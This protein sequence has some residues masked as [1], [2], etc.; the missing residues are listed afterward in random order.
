RVV[1]EDSES[2]RLGLHR[3]RAFGEI[4]PYLRQDPDI[5]ALNRECI[6][7]NR[8]CLHYLTDNSAAAQAALPDN[9]D[10][11][12]SYRALLEVTPLARLV[13]E[14]EISVQQDL[15]QATRLWAF[16]EISTKATLDI[17]DVHFQLKAHRRLLAESNFLTDKMI[18]L[19]TVSISLPSI[20]VLMAQ[21]ATK[22][23]NVAQTQLL[24]ELL[25]PLSIAEH[26]LRRALRGEF[27]Y[28]L[29]KADTYPD[30]DP[31]LVEV[32]LADFPKIYTYVAERSER[33]WSEYW[34]EG[35]DVWADVPLNISE[36]WYSWN[37]YTTNIRYID[38]H[39]SLLRAL[40]EIYEGRTNPG[41]PGLSPPARW[42]WQWHDD[43]EEL[44]LEAGDIHPSLADEALIMCVEYLGEWAA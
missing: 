35:L 25:Q 13:E 1:V 16:R 28:F 4:D 27:Q 19:A 44:C 14:I 42:H 17:R 41:I 30:E 9:P 20:N 34:S 5:S 6:Q 31:L 3:L 7:L 43:T 24:E 10:Y 40:R 22:P 11:W 33:S 36:V 8:R 26:S 29:A 38:V 15:I 23:F 37:T 39:L 32:A 2:Y 18:Y 21:R 12:H